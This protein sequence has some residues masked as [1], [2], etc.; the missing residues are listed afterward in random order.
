MRIGAVDDKVCDSMRQSFGLAGARASD[1]EKWR[2]LII[3]GADAVLYSLAL[4]PIEFA[5]ISGSA[6]HLNRL[7]PHD[8]R[9]VLG[10]FLVKFSAALTS[11]CDS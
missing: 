4:L 8:R 5:E 6:S 1:N 3:V 10:L 11:Q 9:M 7:H 2:A